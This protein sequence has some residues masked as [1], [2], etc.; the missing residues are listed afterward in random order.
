MQIKRFKADN[1]AGALSLIKQEFGSEAVILSAR[2]L[3]KE[4]GV[5]GLL[6]KPGVEVTAATDAYYHQ[7]K[8]YDSHQP[9]Q[10]CL[11]DLSKKKG[12]IDTLHERMK[13]LKDRCKPVVRENHVTQ[14]GA[15]ELAMLRQHLLSQGVEEGIALELIE[16]LNR[17]RLSKGPLKVDEIKSCLIRTLKE[18]GITAGPIDVN[19]G[20]QRIIVFVGPTG[21]GKTTTIAKLAAVRALQM[22]KRVALITLDNH[23]IGGIEQLKIF[24]RIIGVPVEVASNNKELKKSIKNLKNKDLILIDTAGMSRRDGHRFSELKS[25]FNKMRR[26]EIQLLLDATTKEKDLV[27]ILER[28]KAISI[29]RLIFTKLDESTTY[30]NILN[31]LIR[32]KIPIS[33]FT[34]GQQVPEDIEIASLEKLVDLIMY[35]EKEMELSSGPPQTMNYSAAIPGILKRHS[36]KPKELVLNDENRGVDALNPHFSEFYVANK[37][38]DVFHCPD[39]KWAKKIK[40]ENLMVFECALDAINKDFKPCRLC[41]PDRIEKHNPIPESGQIK[42]GGSYVY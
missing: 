32:T 8:K 19:H 15:N 18:M 10:S 41:N 28:F 1:M 3:K 16:K 5:F 24:A 25:L 37:K 34:N 38:S 27:D 40:P 31:Q 35:R 11:D 9:V 17:T 4:R 22:K 36:G 7:V 21:V 39:C 26:V 12:L 33:Y 6:T 29:S 42:M 2:S 30:G 14:N 20:K 23:R 13:A